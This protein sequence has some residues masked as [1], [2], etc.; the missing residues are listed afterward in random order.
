[1]FRVGFGQ[2][3]HRFSGNKDKKLI[4]GGVEVNGERGLE[5]NSDG[6]L[7]LHAICAA[8]EQALGRVNFSVYADAMCKNGI[9]DSGEYLKV[10]LE[11]LREDDYSIN[12][13]G[14]SIEAKTPKILPVEEKMK[15]KLSEILS[16]ERTKIGINATTGEGL[17]AFGLAEGIQAFVIISI[18]KK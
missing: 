10:A 12:N 8:I 18:V 9:K 4:L 11:H 2:D 7:I 5:S 14:I 6:D 17:T 3:S 13:L 1:M 15:D 16:I